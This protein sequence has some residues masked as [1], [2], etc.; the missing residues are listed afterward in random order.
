MSTEFINFGE[1]IVRKAQIT[2]QPLILDD[3][4]KTTKRFLDL[5]REAEPEEEAAG[6]TVHE[7][8]GGGNFK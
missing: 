8:E 3:L 7:K 5:A 1:R 4:K 6:S 2:S